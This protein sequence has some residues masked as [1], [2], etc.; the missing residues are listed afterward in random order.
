M[1][2][3]HSRITDD[4]L[5]FRLFEKQIMLNSHT[6]S[7]PPDNSEYAMYRRAL[8]HKA[9]EHQYRLMTMDTEEAIRNK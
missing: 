4:S 9:I 2:V 1:P 6:P 3:K 7:N 8:W 5:G